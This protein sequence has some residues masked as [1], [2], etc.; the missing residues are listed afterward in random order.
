MDVK[1]TNTVGSRLRAQFEQV[2]GDRI[3]IENRWLEDLR[4]FKGKYEPDEEAR[5]HKNKSRTFTRMT[6]VKVKSAT[7]RLMD[8]V[9]PA[10]S[11]DN[12]SITP[13]PV[14]NIAPNPYVLA[15]I[16]AQLQRTP[17]SDEI[18]QILMAEATYASEKMQQEIR[19][20]LAEIKYRRIMKSVIHSGNLFGTGVMKGPLVNR[21]SS[22]AW[23]LD[24][25]G[26]WSL[27]TK[28]TLSPF[29][30]FIP[31]W[32]LYPDPSATLLS[33]AQF[34]YQRPVMP[35]H[36]VSALANRP[37]FNKQAIRRYLMDNPNGD[38]KTLAW[39]LEL[40]RL[41]L[42]ISGAA[43]TKGKRYE[44]LEYWGVLD[45]ED[46][47]S[48]GLELPDTAIDEYWSNV[49]LLGDNIIKAE[50]QPIEGM[51]LP[52]YAYYW[53][54]DETSIFGEGIAAIMRDDQKA[55]NSSTRVML[56]NAAICGGPMVE[57]NVDLL[58]PGE[59]PRD[60]HPFKVWLRSGVGVEA[61]YPAIRAINMDSHLQEYLAMA[62]FF[63]NNIHESTI[64]SY[65][66]GEASSKGS[67]GRTA[68][69]L[70]MLMSAAQ[71]MFKDQLF[72][73]DDDIQRPFIEG[74]YH[75]N[76]QFNPKPEIRGDF[77]V[78]VKGTS[79][80]VAREIRAQNLDQFANSTMNQF[81]APFID[82]H[83]LNTQRA[84]VLELGD[85]IVLG[86]E[87]ALINM[88]NQE[89]SNEPSTG[90]PIGV[91]PVIGG[92]TGNEPD[93]GGDNYNPTLG[94]QLSYN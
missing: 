78:V 23:T 16:T 14:P 31:L 74:M 79:S 30:D 35:K 9:F 29:I 44:V 25:F 72:S 42:N 77:S 18:S 38:A 11:E 91:S 80:L 48:M 64:P 93:A 5:I 49:W 55:L 20:Q 85:D 47:E 53:D 1:A 12:W 33:E 2:K 87:Q 52:Y 63:M 66:H 92:G 71:I 60:L 10:G 6:R 24:A 19:D 59:D 36:L 58:H 84:S 65:M 94:T 17:T 88:T 69:G 41:G 8:L 34:V 62:N 81:D 50:V 54:K 22:K 76:M 37:D 68:S 7:A 15:K 26:A 83:A 82:R 70:S 13:T 39:E 89:L 61:Q 3:E 51:Q 28:E 43:A 46:L 4:Q 32:E 86:K 45:A 40:R 67:V 90:S 56:D 75:W 27:T 57:V 21:K 73:L